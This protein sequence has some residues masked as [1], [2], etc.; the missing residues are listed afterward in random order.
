MAFG[1]HRKPS[2]QIN[3][4]Y[5][6]DNASNN[7]TPS[8]KSDR[9]SGGLVTEKNTVPKNS[10]MALVRRSSSDPLILFHRRN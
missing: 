4:T 6:S 7:T 1:E 8:H 3:S 2:L 9:S 5:I 10:Q